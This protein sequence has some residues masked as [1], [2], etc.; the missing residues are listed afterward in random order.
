MFGYGRGCGQPLPHI[1]ATGIGGL[2][3][4]A[5]KL[6]HIIE[7]EIFYVWI[8]GFSG[9]PSNLQQRLLSGKTERTEHISDQVSGYAANRNKQHQPQ[10]AIELHT[11]HRRAQQGERQQQ[12][13]QRL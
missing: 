3:A 8:G 5:Q 10:P 7:F 1:W 9:E 4:A 6:L 13:R 11:D 12:Q 2:C